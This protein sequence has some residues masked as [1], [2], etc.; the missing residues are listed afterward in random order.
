M[1]SLSHESV[2]DNTR[3]LRC[4]LMDQ[5]G[6]CQFQADAA[7]GSVLSESRVLRRSGVGISAAKSV[8]N[9]VEIVAC[10]DSGCVEDCGTCEILVTIGITALM[11]ESKSS[12]RSRCGAL[13]DRAGHSSAENRPASFG[14][15]IH[16]DL[17]MTLINKNQITGAAAV[18][19]GLLVHAVN[20]GDCTVRS[21][22]ITINGSVGSDCAVCLDIV[23]CVVDKEPALGAA[24]FACARVKVVKLLVQCEETLLDRAVFGGNKIVVIVADLSVAGQDPADADPLRSFFHA[25]IILVAADGEPAAAEISFRAESKIHITDLMY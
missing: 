19:L 3:I 9:R 1:K 4:C 12:G 23:H 24:L 11:V 8:Q 10:T 5:L 21:D 13:A 25:G 14:S 2:N 17:V 16:I 15:L 22:P 6:I 7:V 18:A 20:I